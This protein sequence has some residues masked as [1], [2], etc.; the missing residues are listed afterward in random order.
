MKDE[1]GYPLE[2]TPATIERNKHISN[3]LIEEDIRDVEREIQKLHAMMDAEKML[4]EVDVSEGDRRMAAFR[5]GARPGQIK[6]RKAFIAFLRKLL[7]ARA[8]QP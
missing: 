8:E 2:I 3:E 1:Y 5:A 7:A 6:Q 4:S